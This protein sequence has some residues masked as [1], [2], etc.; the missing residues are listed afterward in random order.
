MLDVEAA[1][2]F[3]ALTLFG[4]ALVVEEGSRSVLSRFASSPDDFWLAFFVVSSS[5]LVADAN[6]LFF[7][8]FPESSIGVVDRLLELD[9]EEFPLVSFFSAAAAEA[10]MRCRIRADDGCDVSVLDAVFDGVAVAVLEGLAG[11]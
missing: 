2:F 7:F 4:P 11:G 8:M 9:S 3:S 6:F 1:S 5:L 10:A